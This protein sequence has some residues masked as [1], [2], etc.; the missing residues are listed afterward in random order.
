MFRTILVTCLLLLLLPGSLVL[1]Q[2]EPAPAPTADEL[3]EEYLKTVTSDMSKMDSAGKIECA[4]KLVQLWMNGDVDVK[5]KK[6]IP[7]L[8]EKLARDDD[9]KVQMAAIDS[10]GSLGGEEAA[11]KVLSI[12]EKALK[13]KEPSVEAYGACFRA[14]KKIACTDGKVVGELT[15]YFRHKDDDVISKALDAAAGYKD[16]DGE[17]RKLLL[18]ES[19]KFTAGPFS[20]SQG[21]DENAK[22]KWNIIRT[23]AMSALN[24]LS[25]QNFKD[26]IEAQQWY[27]KAKKDKNLWK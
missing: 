10:L 2:E 13:E 20:G 22:R 19:I 5:V 8:L 24:S 9:E 25:G 23:G 12:L 17:T 18:E 16:A 1:A 26:P 27:Q 15:K 14:L 6:P 4:G 3:A 11:K 21:S 7:K